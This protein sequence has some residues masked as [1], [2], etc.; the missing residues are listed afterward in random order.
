MA[1][2]STKAPKEKPS[3]PTFL[4][5]AQDAISSLADKKGSS[6]QRIQTYI[7][8]KYNIDP[9]V[10]RVHLKPALARG[11]EKEIFVRPKNSD[12]KGYTGSFKINKTKAA[13]EEK[14]KARKEKE[15]A[16]K[17]KEKGKTKPVK[18]TPVKKKTGTT[19]GKS[20]KAKKA[21]TISKAKKPARKSP[22]KAAKAIKPKVSV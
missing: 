7:A 6:V 13:T 20:P 16:K 17:E 3:R 14:E 18:K 2:T 1:D 9:D 15:R 8:E 19:T 5:M 10:V 12:A 11:L 21:V 4:K 22:K